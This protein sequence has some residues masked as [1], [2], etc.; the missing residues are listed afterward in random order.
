MSALRMMRD[1]AKLADGIHSLRLE[2]IRL[3][4]IGPF[5]RALD[6]LLALADEVVEHAEG[7]AAGLLEDEEGGI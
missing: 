1:A 4:R 5:E 7:V 3:D 2:M 6:D